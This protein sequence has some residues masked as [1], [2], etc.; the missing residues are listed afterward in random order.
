M[1]LHF[2]FYLRHYYISKIPISSKNI[3]KFE[4]F[5]KQNEKYQ[6]ERMVDNVFFDREIDSSQPDKEMTILFSTMKV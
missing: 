6:F 1:L 4:E 5:Q 3:V 2:I